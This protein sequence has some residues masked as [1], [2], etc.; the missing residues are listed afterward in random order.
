M[1]Y[2]ILAFYALSCFYIYYS[3]RVSKSGKVSIYINNYIDNVTDDRFYNL[4]FRLSIINIIITISLFSLIVFGNVDEVLKAFLLFVITLLFHF[5]NYL[6]VI[7][8]EKKLYINK[9]VF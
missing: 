6:V 9:D 5:L 3:Y 1:K 2:L 8:G 7:I 4:Q